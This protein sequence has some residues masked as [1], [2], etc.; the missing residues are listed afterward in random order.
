MPNTKA[1]GYAIGGGPSRGDLK[2][3]DT[4][5]TAVQLDPA[6]GQ[7]PT[8][9]VPMSAATAAAFAGVQQQM[10]DFAAGAPGGVQRAHRTVTGSTTAVPGERLR[11]DASGGP[12][13]V[14]LPNPQART[15]IDVKKV[16]TGPHAVT[17][18]AS[19]ASTVLTPKA[20]SQGRAELMP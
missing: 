12:V 18:A 1:S 9:I 20:G 4:H 10:A 11:V 3:Q 13:T 19:A 17:L 14:T 8:S 7:L 2:R 16:D 5:T 6:T 15:L